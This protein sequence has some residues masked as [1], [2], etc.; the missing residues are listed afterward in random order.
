MTRNFALLGATILDGERRHEGRALVIGEGRVLALADPAD[1]PAGLERIAF[2]GGLI[3]PG[4]VDLQVNG[5]GG[6]LFNQNPDVEAIAAI[7]AAHAP[8]G[9]T[10]LLPTAITDRPEV[11]RAALDAARAAA[12]SGVAGF[13]GVHLEGPHLSLARKGAHS[14]ALIRA[15]KDAD[16]D[17]IIAARG[18]IPTVLV[19]LAP[20]AATRAQIGALAKAG[21]IVSLGH[22]DA[23]CAA[24]RAAIEAGAGMATHLFNAMSQMGNREPGLVGAVLETGIWAGLI[25]DGI[26]VAPETVA[27]ALRAKRGPGR[28]FLVTDS[29]PPIGTDLAGFEL[30]GREVMR[31]E[32]ALRLGDGTLAGA[33][34][35]MIDAVRWT[36][37]VIGLELDEA[38]RMA[39]LYPAMAIGR[40]ETLGR[41]RAGSDASFVHLTDG[42]E[43]ASV[44]RRG[45]KVA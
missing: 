32:G 15:M 26:H 13:A 4:F 20:E 44:W 8:F 27:I 43:I 22:S 45:E 1:L 35:T 36:H 5:G 23:S 9:T 40:D 29:M 14:P 24:A 39:S 21:V 33:D 7:S 34:L 3:A 41:L 17:L 38:L 28:I 11:T 30:N 18:A 6:V 2:E 42:L 16:R 31:S 19:T 25:A 37:R 12:R 10:A